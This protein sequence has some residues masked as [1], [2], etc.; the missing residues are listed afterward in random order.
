M[1]DRIK[2]LL[3]TS[4]GPATPRAVAADTVLHGVLQFDHSNYWKR[5]ITSPK[6]RARLTSRYETLSYIQDWEEGF[7]A[8]PRLDI[9]RC[10]LLNVFD[11]AQARR[12]IRDYALIVVLHSAVGDNLQAINR[13]QSI[14]QAR[15]GRLLAL[16][17]NEYVLMPEKIGFL[18]SVGADFV[19]SQLPLAAA[20]WLYEDCRETCVLPAPHAL[21]ARVYTRQNT[22]ERPID[23]GFIG[24][25]YPWFIGDIER[26]QAIEL[27][28]QRSAEFGL[29]SDFRRQR[30]A[31]GE[32]VSFLNQTYG[33]I[34]GESGTYYLERDDRSQ[35][36]VTE[37][38]RTN[39]DA[40][41]DDVFDRFFRNHPAP[42]S[43]KAISSRHFEPIGT[44]ACQILLEGEYNG[45]LRAGEHYISLRKD[46]ANLHEVV[47][48][49]SDATYRAEMVERT[50]DYVLAE[51]THDVRVNALIDAMD[52]ASPTPS[53]AAA[54]Q[55]KL[56]VT[57]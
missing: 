34:G 30:L 23:I 52:S 16:I 40:T 19:G 25:F 32:W 20:Q 36:A 50:R 31:R 26:T 4:N 44:G 22:G 6:M 45:I 10:N 38:L 39:P 12:H 33:V 14:L 15:K 7:T 13:V 8:S 49:F 29:R 17:G 48:Q 1:P 54:H 57:R 5:L 2:T 42:V 43:G 28:Q 51:H 27:F 41:F 53:R 18:R 56:G 47:E 37:L 21:N 11:V 35:R 3:I 46:H 9:D 24:D 55:P